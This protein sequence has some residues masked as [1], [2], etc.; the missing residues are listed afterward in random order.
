[1]VCG[2]GQGEALGGGVAE[3]EE[4]DAG[5]GAVGGDG[6]GSDVQGE[7]GVVSESY[8]GGVGGDSDGEGAAVLGAAGAVGFEG[9]EL[10]FGEGGGGCGLWRREGSGCSETGVEDEEAG[11]GGEHCSWLGGE[12]VQRVMRFGMQITRG[13]F[14]LQLHGELGPDIKTNDPMEASKIC[15]CQ[16][17][18]GG[19][20]S[21]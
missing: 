9:G 11:E 5:F 13:E 3:G 10:E 4:G 20:E 19:G 8:G 21:C 7:W 17:R 6:V 2:A 15:C 18:R 14:P 16:S 12:G 1:M